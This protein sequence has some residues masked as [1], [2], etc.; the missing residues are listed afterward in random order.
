MCVC[1]TAVGCWLS[2]SSDT[3]TVVFCGR[4]AVSSL[5][6]Q[7]AVL[8]HC[9]CWRLQS[10]FPQHKCDIAECSECEQVFCNCLQFQEKG[11]KKGH[12]I[13]KL[14]FRSLCIYV[15][16]FS[17]EQNRCKDIPSWN[18]FLL[19]VCFYRGVCVGCGGGWP[20]L[21]CRTGIVRHG[22]NFVGLYCWIFIDRSILP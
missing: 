13:L 14:E 19:F 3:S 12:I 22:I 10:V 20:A 21:D 17:A 7:T 15:L 16:Y 4:N 5:T 18:L 1:L 9:T 6:M 2:S 11:L 8:F